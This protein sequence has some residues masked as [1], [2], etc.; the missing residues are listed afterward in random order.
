MHR[1]NLTWLANERRPQGNRS[2]TGMCSGTFGTILFIWIAYL[3][4]NF[5]LSAIQSTYYVDSN[6]NPTSNATPTAT[7][8]YAARGAEI[9]LGWAFYIFLFVLM[10]KTRVYIRNKYNI[11]NKHCQ[12]SCEDVCCVF[13]CGCCTV[14]QMARH[15]ADYETYA[16]RCCSETGLPHNVRLAADEASGVAPPPGS[17]V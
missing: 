2:F 13:W 16:A 1:L 12:G 14:A 10:C 17:V 7:G 11:R 8:F 9:A 5:I 4:I 3:V 15:T 6:G